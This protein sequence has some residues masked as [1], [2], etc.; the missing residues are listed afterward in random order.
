MVSHSI[1]ITMNDT[2]SSRRSLFWWFVSPWM[3]Q[4]RQDAAYSGDSYHHEWHHRQDAA[5]SD[6]S[7]HHEWHTIVKMQLILMIRI[8]MNDTPSSRS[9]L[10][11]WFV[12]PWMTHHRQDAA[13]SGDSYHHEWHTIVKTQLILV[14]RITMNDTPSSRRSLFWWFVSPWMT[15]HRQD[16]AYSDDSY[17]H[18]WHTIVKTQL[19]LMIRITMNDTPSSRCS[20]FWWFVSPWMTHHRQDAAYSDDS[21]HHE[22]LTI[23]KMLLILVIRIT[24]NDTSSSRCSLFWWFVSPWMTNHRQDAAYSDDSYHHEW[25]TIV[26]ML[27]IL[28]I[29]T[30]MNDTPSSRCSLFWWF[31]PPWMTHHRQDAAYSGDSYH[32]EWHT[33]VK[34]Q[35]ILVIRITMNDTPS[36]RCSLF[37]WFVSTIVKTQLILVIRITM[38]DTPSSRRSLFWWFVSPWMTHHRQDAVILMIR[39]T[40]NDTPSSRCSLFW[41]F[42]P[43]WMTHHHQDAAYSEDSYHHEWYTIVKTQLIL[44]IRIT[45]N[46]TPSSRC[47]LFW[48]FV[49]PWMTHHRQDAAYSGDSYHHEW[50]TIVKTQFILVIRIT[51]NDTSSSRCSYSDDSHHHEWLTIVKMLLILVIRITMNDTSSSRCSLFWWFVSPWMT[52]HRQDAAYSGDSYHHEWLTI[53]KMQLILM[54]RTTMNDTPSS[55]CCLFWW[56]VPPWMTHHRQDAAYSDD[57]YHHEW[58]TIVKT[59]LILVIRI[60]MNDTPSSRRSLF[61][62]FVSPWM[63]HH[64]QDAAY[65]DDSYHHEWHTIV[66]TQLILVIRITMNDTPSSRCSLFW[67]FVSPWMT[68]HRQDAAYS[69]DSYHHEWHT[70]VKMQ[71]IL[72]IR[73]TM[74]D[75]PSSRRSLFWWF[76]SPWMTH[77]RQDA[78]YSGDSYH[79][80]WH[81]IVKMQLILVIRITMNDTPSSRRSLFW[82]FVSP[83]MTHHRQDAAYSDDSYHHEWHTI[84]KMQ[85][86]LVI[87]ITMNDTPSS[88]RSLFWWFVSPWMTHH[89]QDAAYSD[90]SYHHEWHTIVKTQL[91]LMIRITMN[92]TPSSRR[93]L[94][95]WFVS[96]W[97]THHRQ[98]AAYSDDSYHHEWHTIVK[99]QL[100]LM[101]RITMNDTPSSRCSLFWWFVSPWMTHHRQDAAYS[102]DSYHH[103]W[104]TI[105][106]MQLILMIRITMNDTPSSRRSL[107]WWFVSP[108]MTHHRQDAAYSDDSYHHE[109]HTIVKMQL[110]LMI[111]ITMNDTPSSRCSLFWWFVS[112]WMTH[113]RQ[114]AAYSDDSYHHEWHTIVKMQLILVIRITMNDTPSSRC[115]LFWWFVSPWMT[116]H[117]QDAAYSDDSYHHEWHTIVKTQLILMIRI[118]MNDTPSSRRSLFWWFVSPWMTHHRQDAAYSDDSYHHE[119][120][121]IVKTQLILMIRITMND[122]P[123]SRC[124]L[125]WW[126]ISPWMTHHRQDAAYSGD[127]YHHEWHTI[128]KTQLILMIRH[129]EC[130]TRR[131]SWFVWMTHHEWHTIVKIRSLFWWFVS[132]WM[133]HHRQDAAYS[134]DSYHHEWHTIVKNDTQLILVIRI[135]MNDTPSSRCSL[136]WWFVSPWMTHHEWHTIVKTQLI[137]VIRITMNDTP[138]SR[139]SLFWWFVSPWMTPS[140]RCSLFWWFVPPW[141]THHRL[142]HRMTHHRQDATYSDDSYHHEWHTIVKMQLI[143]VIRI[144]MNDTPSSRRSLFWWFVSPWMTHHRQDAAYSDDSYHHEWHTIVKTQLI[145][146]IRITMNDTIVKTQLILVI[147]IT[148][149]D[150]PSSRRSLFW[151]FV[152]PWMTHHR[153]DA[154]Y[155]GDSYH[156]EWHTIVKTQLILMIRITM[157]DTPSSRCSLFWWFVSPWMTHHRQDAAY[158][159]DSYH[160]EWHT[161]VKMQ[162]ILMIR[163]TMNDTP[164]SRRS[165]FW[166]FVSP[167]M[168]HHRQ[169]AAYSDD[170][171]HHEW[172]TI[173]KTQLILVIRIT[174]NDSPSSRRSLFWWFVSPWMTHHRQDAA[175]SDDSYHHEWLTIVKMQL[176]LMIRITMNDTP[177]TRRSLFWWFV[178]PWM[179]H[180]RQDAAYSDDWYHHEWHTIVKM[181]LILVIRITMNDSPSSRRSLFWWFVSPWMTHHRQD[182]AYSDDSYH[183][184]WHTIV[185]TQLILV[186]R[187]TMNDTPSSRRS[188]FWWFVSPWMTHHRQDA[189]YSGDS[190]HHEWHT[191]VKTQLI[192]MIRITM[193]DTPSSICSLFWWFVSPWMTHHRQDAVY[194]GDSYHHEWHTIVKMQLILMIRIT[195]NDTP[196]SRRSL[197]WWFISPWMTHHR[198]DAAYSDDSYHHEWHTIVKTQLILVIRITMNDTPSS[199]CSLFWWFVPPW[200]T[201][202]RQDTAYSGDSYHH[203]QDAAY[204]DDSYHHEW[205][206]IVKTQLILMIRITMNDTPSSRY[207]LFW[208]FVSPSSRCSL[209]W[210]FVSPWMT[211]HRQDAAY[212]DDSYHHEWHTIVKTQLILMIRITM[213]DTPS[214]KCSLFWWFVLPWMTHHRQD[215]AYSDDSY[216]HEWHTI[217]KTQ[218]ILVIR[219][220][221]NDTPLS[222]RSL[223]WWFVSPWMTHH[224]QD[225]AYS[226][227]SYHHE[228]HTIVKTQLILMIRITMNDTPSSICSLFWWFVSPWMTHH[229]QDAAY[230]DDSYH[231]EWHTIVKMQLI[232][233]IRITIVKMQLILMIRITMNDTPSS[234]RSLFWWFVSPW[235]THHRQDA[236]YSG[237]SYH[238]EWHT[239]VKTQLILMIRITMNDTPSSRCSLFW[240]FVSPWMTHHRQDAAYSDDSYHHEWHT[241]VNMQ[242]IL[243]IRITMNDTPS[244]RRSL[245]WW[246]VSPWMT[247]HRQ[248][249]AYSDDSYHHEWHTIVKTQ[250]ILM[251][252]ITMNDTPSSRCSLFWWFVSPSSRCSL[253][254]WFV[255]PWMTHH[256]Q[257]TAYSDDSY[258]HEWHTIVK[259]QLILVI[260][261]TMNDT[262][263][264]RCSLFWWFVPPWMTHHRQDTAYSDDSYHHEWHTIVKMQ[265]ILM[266][267]ITMN[268]TPSSKC[269]LFWWF[270]SPWMTHHRQDAAYSDDSYHHKWHTIVKTQLILMIRITMNDTPSSKCSLFWWFVS[271][272]MTHHRQDAA[273]SDDSYHHEW[274]TIVKMQL[275]LMI[276]ITMNDTPSSR[277]SLFWWFVSPWMTHH[278]QD[279]AYSDDSYH[280]EWHTIVKMQL[281]LVIR[282]TMNDTPS[283]RR[284]LFWWFVSPW[285]T[286]HRQDAAYSGDSYH[287]EYLHG[288]CL[289]F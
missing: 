89:R 195:M 263:S 287:H 264:S 205:H 142:T 266:I 77:H 82:W 268:D 161:I 285:M 191:I 171:Y 81:T 92:D 150:T 48:W 177:S 176:I 202:H 272:W 134:D 243:M 288:S 30:T 16:A 198:Q 69:D 229:R 67:W 101:I 64:R 181:Q 127:S 221:M 138:S 108:W 3:T 38:N 238:H 210:W 230:S 31:V 9:S 283:S 282:I 95:W 19:I 41:W 34:T 60:T 208:W 184:E 183:H 59:Q 53:V 260:R 286:H 54:I 279:A 115:S 121:T 172:H 143:L 289:R 217:V 116:H 62:W 237:D 71:L 28:M 186:I 160:H 226:G 88:R 147:R 125:F 93:S 98:D 42:V 194:S 154:A 259:M 179:T 170:S 173:V 269:S 68:H 32:H 212:S 104:H 12:S 15:H 22:W 23:V 105:V 122:T 204:S 250:L 140:S 131:R 246:F 132:P 166:W 39:I 24:M 185:K 201:H 261:I 49:S 219:T 192:L 78:A 36:S 65:S 91:I 232:L 2:P 247:H 281:I 52:H 102:D 178:P 200:M 50:H 211:H 110:I 249:A 90:D 224:R 240:W 253:F 152:S 55:R 213:N 76:V 72:M 97:M 235:M 228:W 207:S 159:D 206:T 169:D 241:I 47:S 151:W 8:T 239:I 209:F 44:M 227:D 149:N 7:Y 87:R 267:R 25:H 117:R 113:H 11:W 144:T 258:H 37:W 262:P 129:H 257:D 26:K 180:H 18:E 96:P 40:M 123:S 35:L 109:W 63:T 233:V 86:I 57:S 73:I 167:W 80:E 197:F 21:H 51:M 120:H 215:A 188:L 75:T 203:R 158:S 126:F 94:F 153:Q 242:L 33:I 106:K 130:S 118:T 256:R 156:H 225:A 277:C 66:K 231:H 168:T 244:S 56:F 146:M 61:W 223:F 136:F 10:F 148:M 163:I 162:L 164:S 83:W 17:H 196:S 236:A 274:H 85:L 270:V 248:Y 45:M 141:M 190:Y 278:R 275:I 137:L 133:T 280:H 265:L 254:W 103:E 6:D 139:R 111:R 187:T 135:T 255:S 4:H 165:L 189:A 124:S 276:R 214:S 13:Y 216:H 70:I 199:R 107:F 1:H 119:W 182:A 271:P 220:T 222:R 251:I 128:V 14:I 245:F 84:V 27:L 193:N 114:D 100:I 74:N 29:R 79:H 155:S 43:P 157:N 5:Y 175:Y 284:S 46:D 145:L 234:R 58:H 218:L 20:L 273:Y 252:R 174:M 112:P 99:M